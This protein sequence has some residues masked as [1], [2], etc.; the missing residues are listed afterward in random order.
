MM[1][2]EQMLFINDRIK[3]LSEGIAATKAMYSDLWKYEL[4]LSAMKVLLSITEN[5]VFK[6]E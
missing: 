1:N 3:I 2:E 5:K 6:N 4:E